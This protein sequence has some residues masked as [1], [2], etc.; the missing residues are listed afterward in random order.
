MRSAFLEQAL[1][2]TASL[3]TNSDT[4]NYREHL[5]HKLGRGLDQLLEYSGAS[6]DQ[7]VS[8][9]HVTWLLP[10]GVPTVA[11]SM[12]ASPGWPILPASSSHSQGGCNQQLLLLFYFLLENQPSSTTGLLWSPLGHVLCFFSAQSPQRSLGCLCLL[13]PRCLLS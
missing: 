12:T 7:G 2:L 10:S 13:L 3:I 6:W 9:W 11:L 1:M 4:N 8:S 5:K